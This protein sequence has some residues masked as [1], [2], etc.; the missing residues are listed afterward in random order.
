MRNRSNVAGLVI[1]W[2]VVILLACSPDVVIQGLVGGAT[3]SPA[4]PFTAVAQLATPSALPTTLPSPSSTVESTATSNPTASPTV[5]QSLGPSSSPTSRPPTNTP[6]PVLP[7]RS[8]LPALA[9]RDWPRP[10]NDNG[11]CF[12]FLPT[13]YFSQRDFDI[14]IPRLQGLQAR[15]VLVIYNDEN[16]LKL[17]APQ[18]KKAGIIPVWRK[19]MRAYQRYYAWDRDIQILKDAG[20]PPYFQIY[21]EPDT[22]EEWDGRDVNRDQWVP[23]FVQAAKDVYNAGG[24]VGLQV[25]DEDWL[26]AVIQ[27]VKLQKGDR[28]FGRM[29][30]V[31]HPYGLNHPPNFTED[32]NGVLG[33]RK[34][35]DLFQK[36]VGFV[37]PFIAGEGGWKYKATDDNRFPMVDDKLHAQYHVELFNWFRVGKLSDGQPLPDYLFAFCPWILAGQMEGA[38]WYDSFE[39]N[40]ETTIAAVKKIPIFTRKFSW[41]K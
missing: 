20:L 24:Y 32:E 17:A 8:D 28:L 34:A 12:H 30:F 11:R 18:F 13:G 5:V 1:A 31:P 10:A 39:G 6:P 26:S 4:A 15:W 21:N 35:A 36:E 25:L 27:Q 40:R 16:Q 37:P 14:Q 23:Y 3:S 9:L 2:T 29:F 41:D 22:G 33:F 19:M 38:A 7:L